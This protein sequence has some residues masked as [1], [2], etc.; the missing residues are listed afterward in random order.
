MATATVYRYNPPNS[1]DWE[2]RLDDRE[3][4]R[5]IAEGEEEALEEFMSRYEHRLKGFLRIY[6][7]N[8]ADVDEAL[9]ETMMAVWASAKRY[10][11]KAEPCFWVMGIARFK[12]FRRH[13][14]NRYGYGEDMDVNTPDPGPGP[15]DEIWSEEVRRAVRSL[16]IKHREVVV[17]TYWM[18][19]TSPEIAKILKIRSP[20]TVRRR[21]CLARERL[22]EALHLKPD[23]PREIR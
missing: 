3:L 20:V 8:S 21:L 23:D 1:D 15:D 11:G 6:L 12:A 18:G 17:L 13:R 19:C 10:Q 16:P 22:K 14:N 4:L 9:S 2:E 7:D 5:L